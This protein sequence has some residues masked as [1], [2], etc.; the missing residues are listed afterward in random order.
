MEQDIITSAD[1]VRTPTLEIISEE[2][3]KEDT[4]LQDSD[5]DFIRQ[6]MNNELYNI[7]EE[8][9]FENIDQNKLPVKS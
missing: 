8:E 2:K 4:N 6:L 9:E 3:S 1:I 7:N 5:D